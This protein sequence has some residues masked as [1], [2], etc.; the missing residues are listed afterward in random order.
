MNFDENIAQLEEE[1]RWSVSISTMLREFAGQGGDGY[2]YLSDSDITEFADFVA[3][4]IL[5][6]HG[7]MMRRGNGGTNGNRP[8]L[9]RKVRAA[10][11]AGSKDDEAYANGTSF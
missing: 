3:P 8:T 4:M 7:D 11:K 5:R 2:W 10:I 6:A 9:W 1:K